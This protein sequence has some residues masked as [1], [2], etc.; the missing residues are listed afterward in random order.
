MTRNQ[1]SY[2]QHL[3]NVKHN[4]EMER[5][6][7]R[8]LTETERS[9]KSREFETHRSNVA[10]E[11]E[12]RRSHLANETNERY[13]NVTDRAKLGETQRSN[14]AN[15]ELKR[16]YQEN[17]Y[18]TDMLNATTQA[19]LVG[20]KNQLNRAQANLV[21]KEAAKY[22]E[23]KDLQNATGAVKFIEEVFDAAG[24]AKKV[25]DVFAQ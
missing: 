11:T 20:T 12:T 9:N 17:R 19:N 18:T 23:S 24:K 21:N 7:R 15:E 14:M 5:Q 1:I 4:R 2:V 3:E 10:Q 22:D 8:G 6:G 25:F 16:E 13:R